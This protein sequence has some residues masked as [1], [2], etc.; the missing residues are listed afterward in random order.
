MTQS[1]LKGLLL[2]SFISYNPSQFSGHIPSSY[3]AKEELFSPLLPPPLPPPPHF[4][5]FREEFWV[6]QIYLGTSDP[7]SLG[8]KS[9]AFRLARP[10]VP[11]CARQL[12][13]GAHMLPAFA[14]VIVVVFLLLF[15]GC[16]G[17]NL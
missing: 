5:L 13:F 12:N 9:P 16:V 10:S 15:G 3:L 7:H 8:I 6:S 11:L 1:L 17:I 14:V 4:Y 2:W